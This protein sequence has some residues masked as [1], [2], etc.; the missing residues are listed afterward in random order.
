MIR[1]DGTDLRIL[2][3]GKSN[4]AFPSW[5]RDG[6]QIVYREA[7]KQRNGLYIVDAETGVSRALITGKAHYNFPAWSPTDDVIAFHQR[8]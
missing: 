8:S 2:T 3:D 1:D 4:Y 5:S 6:R 7:S